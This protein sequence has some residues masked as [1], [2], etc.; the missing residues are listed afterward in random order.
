MLAIVSALQQWRHWLEG[1]EITVVTDH[2]SLRVFRTKAEQPARMLRFLDMIQH[3]NVRIVYRPGKANVLADWLSRPEEGAMTL[4]HGM[5]V[6]EYGFM[7]DDAE[8]GDGA[9]SGSS[10]DGTE[11]DNA[12]R[13]EPIQHL[14]DLRWVDIQVIFEHLALGSTPPPNLQ[15]DWISQHFIVHENALYLVQNQVLRKVLAHGD[16]LKIAVSKHE[17]LGHAS[18]GT[19][20]REV[21]KNHWHPDLELIVYE[22]FK[23]CAS[24]EL[25]KKPTAV[26]EGLTPIP[27]APPL[28]RWA[29]DHSGPIGQMHLLNTI[30]YATGWA[31]SSWVPSTAA[32]FVVQHLE[33]QRLIFGPPKQLISDNAGSFV[34]DEL[35]AWLKKYGVELL[36]TSPYHPRTNGRV[37]R[38][39][40]VIKDI[41][42]RQAIDNPNAGIKVMLQDALNIYN[43]REQE[44]GYSPYFLMFGVAPSFPLDQPPTLA[45]Y[46]REPSPQ[47]E[48]QF[49]QELVAT[50]AAG[51]ARRESTSMR[52]SRSQIRA[53]LQEKKAHHRVYGKGDWVLRQRERKHKQEPF[54]DGPWLVV[55]CH[56]GNTYTLA[57]PGGIK[58]NNRYNGTRLFPAYVRDGHP[59]RSLW[60]ASKRLLEQ[61]RQRIR[62]S[63]G[64]I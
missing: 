31:C 35:G 39:H 28:S 9:G 14:R 30:E 12:V 10:S 18:A 25:M 22:A 26:P 56:A 41:L 11:L 4:L 6:Y 13:R 55:N 15:P 19:T 54:Y 8:R 48:V 49:A 2:D 29:I 32:A 58:L 3:Y 7:V 63:V 24:C 64:G 62:E 43:R 59:V 33:A 23:T 61:D 36:N 52:A 16:L 46:V 21:S 51:H 60:Y 44:T 57:S 42:A 47:E 38:F 53:Y 50:D 5:D 45:P 37:E 17:R 20:I 27:P 34:G 40:G 1:A